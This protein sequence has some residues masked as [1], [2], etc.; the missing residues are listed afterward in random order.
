MEMSVSQIPIPSVGNRK[1]WFNAEEP[2]PIPDREFCDFYHSMDFPNG[3]CV[4]GP[5]D[6]RGRFH[7]YIGYYPLQGKT[8]LDVGTAS[9]FL[10]FSA[11]AMEAKVTALEMEHVREIDLLPFRG[12]PYYSGNRAE[13]EEE[14]QKGWVQKKNAFWYA[15]H[16]NRSRVEMIYSPLKLLRYVD[17]QFDVVLAGAILEHLGD[18]VS[19]IGLIGRVAKE[20]VIVAFTPAEDSEE[21]SMKPITDL[22]NPNNYFTWW[23]LSLGLYRRI[24]SNMGFE[25]EVRPSVAFNT[26]ANTDVERQTIIARRPSFG[27]T[28]ASSVLGS[29]AARDG[30]AQAQQF[31]MQERIR[32]LETEITALRNSTSWRVTR[33]L[34][35][36]GHLRRGR[37][38]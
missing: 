26:A 24:F 13:W 31:L 19:A 14:V 15:W 32:A 8:V 37:W 30:A 23:S 3:E 1:S 21:L 11:E 20:A 2:W 25:I 38:N 7:Q 35:V 22:A 17:R 6:I 29:T 18:P 12:Q 5:W 16:R 34:R 10:A 9:G 33:P 27:R 4:T 36:L 28:V